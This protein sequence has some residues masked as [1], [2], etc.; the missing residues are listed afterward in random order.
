MGESKLRKVKIN[1]VLNNFKLIGM[2]DINEKQY[3]QALDNLKTE[4]LEKS[5]ELLNVEHAWTESVFQMALFHD[6]SN[7]SNGVREFMT[8]VLEQ[9]VIGYDD[10]DNFTVLGL[11]CKV[12][13]DFRD[14]VGKINPSDNFLSWIA[15]LLNTDKDNIKVIYNPIFGPVYSSI[16][17]VFQVGLEAPRLFKGDCHDEPLYSHRIENEISGDTNIDR[18]LIDRILP[19]IIY[20]KNREQLNINLPKRLDEKNDFEVNYKFIDN[21]EASALVTPLEITS[22]WE[23]LE[24]KNFYDAEN[25][26]EI[27]VNNYCL[28]NNIIP[29]NISIVLSIGNDEDDNPCV[30]MSINSPN[31]TQTNDDVDL[32]IYSGN[33]AILSIRYITDKLKSLGLEDITLNVDN[34]LVKINYQ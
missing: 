29:K 1:K 3:E 11:V 26:I 22:A 12:R 24:K 34:N 18:I 19:F 7:I 15:N 31:E 33:D 2:D 10:S 27:H 6:D 21:T 30:A 20:I 8:N 13:H 23:A 5:I 14:I 4:F 17:S 9:G 25:E 32:V 16:F 28:K